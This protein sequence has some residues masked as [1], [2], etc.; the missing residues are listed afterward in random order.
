MTQHQVTRWDDE[1]VRRPEEAWHGADAHTLRGL[2]LELVDAGYSTAFAN[3]LVGWIVVAD[4]AA[5]AKPTVAGYRKA[6]REL[7]PEGPPA[8]RRRS[9]DRGHVHAGRL[10]LAGTAATVGAASASFAGL[11]GP[12]SAVACVLPIILGES[13]SDTSERIVERLAVRAELRAAA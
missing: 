11:S 13:R 1:L 8:K 3:G 10:T 6:L 7:H 2:A 4:A 9:R 12:W 5:A